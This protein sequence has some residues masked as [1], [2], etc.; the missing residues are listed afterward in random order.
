MT[1][2]FGNIA[3]KGEVSE[4]KKEDGDSAVLSQGHEGEAITQQL[5][6]RYFEQMVRGNIFSAANQITVTTI[7]YPNTNYTGLLLYNPINSGKILIPLTLKFAISTAAAAHSTIGILRAH[8]PTGAVTAFTTR[9]T[10]QSTLIGN[11]VTPKGVA[12]SA[13]TTITTSV[14]TQIGHERQTT[15]DTEP[16]EV[17]QFHS[18][19]GIKPGGFIGLYTTRA[20]D[21]LGSITWEE[22]DL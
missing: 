9:L 12:L 13:A 6:G 14:D 22:I 3:L 11:R 20:M 10:P 1:R 4:Q 15:Q 18:L 19:Y 16:I 5:H 8:R 17:F 7:N 2:P 21:G